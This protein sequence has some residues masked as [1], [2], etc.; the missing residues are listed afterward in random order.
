[1]GENN[2]KRSNWQRINLKNIEATPAA[3]FQNSWV[4]SP[5]SKVNRRRTKA[6]KQRLNPE[7]DRAPVGA[8]WEQHHLQKRKRPWSRRL[9]NSCHFPGASPPQPTLQPC[10]HWGAPMSSTPT[11]TPGPEASCHLLIP[12]CIT[13]SPQALTSPAQAQDWSQ[14]G[15]N[16]L[17]LLRSGSSPRGV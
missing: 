16:L 1:M 8:S 12:S 6:A 13:E 10:H 7:A 17:P 5:G 2:S 3:Q 14:W 4:W 9:R 11:P 15:I